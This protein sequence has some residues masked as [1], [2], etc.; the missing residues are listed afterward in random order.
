VRSRI[1]LKLLL[2]FLLVIAVV[3]LILDLSLRSAVESSQLHRSIL[4]GSTWSVLLA[5][6]LAALLAGGFARRMQLIVTFAERV[7]SGDFSARLADSA[8]DEIAQAAVALDR[9]ARKLEESFRAVEDGRQQLE[10]LLNG[11]QDA[12]LAVTAEKRVAWANRSLYR[13]VN[14]V[15]VGAQAVETLRDPDLL[16]ALEESL[17]SGEVRT[18]KSVSVVP[19]SIFDVTI[20]PVP[21]GAVCVL[22]D[23][24][25]IERVEKTRRDFIANVSHELRTPL[26]SIQGYAETLLDTAPAGDTSRDFLEIIRKHSSRMARLTDDLLTLA[27][28]ESGEQKMEFQPVPVAD[29][30]DDALR[31]F[32]ELARRRGMELRT[33]Q[34]LDKVVTADRDAIHQVF[35]N[36]IENATKYASSGSVIELGAHETPDG[37]EFYVHDFGAGIPY[38]HLPRLFERFYR[39]DKERSSETGGTGLGLSIVK[40]IVL[41]HRGRVRVESQLNQGSTFFFTLPLATFPVL[42]PVKT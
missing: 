39:V 6:L 34:T 10:A 40:H 27:R 1:F 22:H 33:T 28:V 20:A 17:S 31:G 19:G 41:N 38:E 29:L 35:S 32:R 14:K 7:A 13:L 16:R 8:S 12:V 18:A 42:A 36:L 37:V 3:T 9:T 21:T 4:L 23:L 11:M 5:M 26:T 30:L 24:T 25:E 2:S 15:R